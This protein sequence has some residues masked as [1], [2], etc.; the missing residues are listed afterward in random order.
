MR[1]LRP[2]YDLGDAI[3][4]ALAAKALFFTLYGG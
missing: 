2:P 3:Y 1:S 4:K